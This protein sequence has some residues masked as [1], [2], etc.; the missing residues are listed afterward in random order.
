M[1][2]YSRQMLLDGF[3]REGQQRLLQSGVMVVGAGGLGCSALTHLAGAGVGRIGILDHD[4]VS[5]ENLHRQTL[6]G[7]EDIGSRKTEAAARRLRDMNPEVEILGYSFPLS[8]RASLELFPLFE[9]ILDCTDNF[10]TRYLVNDACVLTGRPLVS[11]AV[12]RYE[13]QIA[14]FNIPGRDGGR[15]VN[16]RDLLPSPPAPGT[17]ANCSEEGILGTLPGMMGAMQAAEAIKILTGVGEPL[18]GR[19]LSYSMKD[20]RFAEF[21]VSRSKDSHTDMPADIDA[22]LEKDYGSITGN[23][24]FAPEIGAGQMEEL[25]AR[26]DTLVVDVREKDEQPALAYVEHLRIPLSAIE[27]EGL[28]TNARRVVFVCQSGARSLR[29]AFSVSGKAAGPME[30]YSLKGGVMEW[31]RHKNERHV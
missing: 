26:G 25:I 29:A 11:A 9:V 13:G 21:T 14:V 27:R 7:M 5:L 1:R 28:V 16:Y 12:S 10:P 6:Y 20:N 4:I 23:S 30:A 18:S 3:G 31:M 17:V 2:R 22:F 8:N 19:L 24:C 15:P